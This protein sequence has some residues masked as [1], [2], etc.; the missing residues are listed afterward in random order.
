M[1]EWQPTEEEVAAGMDAVS[2]ADVVLG[3]VR[4][5]LAVVGPAIAARALREAADA[6]TAK[7]DAGDDDPWYWSDSADVLRA[8]AAVIDPPSLSTDNKERG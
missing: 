7:Q 2:D 8:R 4:D 6:F 3:D 5:I 1:S